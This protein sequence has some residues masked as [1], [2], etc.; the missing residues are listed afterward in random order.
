MFKVPTRILSSDV[1]H[2]TYGK[3]AETQENATHKRAKRSVRSQQ[4]T[5]GCNEQTRHH[6]KDK[7]ET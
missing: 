6:N 3:V 4:V 7:R 5:Q 2:D 1:D